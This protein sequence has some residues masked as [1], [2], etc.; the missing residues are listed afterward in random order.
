MAPSLRHAGSP[1]RDRVLWPVVT[2]V[3][4]LLMAALRLV[5]DAR[6]YFAD[7]TQTGAFG[8]WWELGDRLRQGTIPV[9]NPSA[10]MGGN[11]FAEGQWGLLNPVTWIIALTA[12]GA[13]DAVI[14]TTVV[15]LVAIVALALGV[16]V[17][18]R[19]FGAARPWAALAGVMATQV[20]FTV[21]MDAASWVTGLFC[22]AVFPWVWWALRR[23]VEDARGPLAYL[24]SSYVL[25]TFG[26]VFGVMMLVVIL[27][28]SLVRALIARDRPRIVRALVASVWGALLTVVIYLPGLLTAGVTDRSGTSVSNDRFLGV[29]LSD[30]GS[31]STPVATATLDAWRGELADAPLVYISWALPLLALF[32]PMSRAAVRRCGPVLIFGLVALLIVVGPSEI[33]PLRW[34]VRFMPYLALAVL[35]VLAV[36]AT[37]AFPARVTRT[38]LVAAV[39]SWALL[40]Y[41]AWANRPDTWRSIVLVAAIQLAAILAV[42]ALARRPAGVPA[43]TRGVLAVA[44]ALAVTAV[45]IVPQARLFPGTPLPQFAVTGEVD[46]LHRV[47]AGA[48]GDGIVVGDVYVGGEYEDSFD[49]RLLG[50][51]WYLA[52]APFVNVYTVLPF[53]TMADDLCM[54]LR[55]STCADAGDVLLEDDSDTGVPVADLMGVS[56]IVQ[57]LRTFPTTPDHLPAGWRVAET[58]DYTRTLVRDTAIAGAGGVSWTGT[59]TEVSVSAQDERGITFTVDRVGDDPR[60]V[61]S[62]LP[63]PGYTVTGAVQADPVRG[64]L[65]TIDVSGAEP[66]D[67]VTVRF[68]PPGSAVQIGAFAA[69]MLLLAAWPPVAWFRRRQARRS[70]SSEPVSTSEKA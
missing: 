64:W 68:S 13:D 23:T 39:I 4:A 46:R 41:L 63:W 8:Q 22:A 11:Y 18:A 16:Y 1:L 29:D 25:I 33:G 61:L 26:Y 54:D 42:A 2:A 12:R 20:G 32:L 56:T 7:D 55:G 19:S 69:A 35:I 49:E 6:F 58:G 37:R 14:H 43:P 57:M 38:G 53:S 15:K 52:D 28:E 45:L 3:A 70:A 5:W 48:P 67:E 60:V 10:W 59:G 17:L 66:G 31:A 21:Y 30:L 44:G 40:T 34:P 47:Q 65:M 36:A 50:N 24:L 9:L 62:R 27:V 51:L